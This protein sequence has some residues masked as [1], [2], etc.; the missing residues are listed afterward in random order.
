MSFKNKNYKNLSQKIFEKGDY[1]IIPIRYQDRFDIMRW[2]NE[3]IFHLRQN[4]IL[5]K[6]AQDNYFNN[7]VSKLFEVQ[8][9]N[10]ILFSYLKNDICI[11][12]GG[13]VHIDWGIKTAEV[14]FI[15]DTKLEKDFFEFHWTIF[16][17]L[18]KK[19]AFNELQFNS[20]FTYAYDLRPHLYPVLEKNNFDFK[21][22]NQNEIE[23]DGKM[24]DA[25]IHECKNPY[26]HL[27][28]REIVKEDVKLIYKWSNDTEVRKQSFNSNSINFKEHKNWF[29]RKLINSNSLLLINEYKGSKIGLV[30][31][32]IEDN[33]CK[34]GVL[35]DEIFRG[36]GLSSLMLIKSS[37]YYF[38]RFKLPIY[39]HIKASNIPSVRAFE[40]AGY[41]FFK[42]NIVNGIN[43]LEYKLEKL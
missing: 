19:V 29:N 18:L 17:S 42:K 40:K 32:E 23:I 3:Q 1:K 20:I 34:V 15:M 8:E 33:K 30:R 6:D 28:I 37:K 39:A 24:I 25:I 5:T 4:K 11:G 2:R 16:L 26:N 38:K 35:L 43:S 9:P 41:K 7:I 13:I 14:S 36:K 10:Q 27:K 22:K 12:Y 31:F 21:S